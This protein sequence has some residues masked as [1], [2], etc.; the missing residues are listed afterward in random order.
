MTAVRS[1]EEALV[2]VTKANQ[3]LRQWAMAT[4]EDHPD[5]EVVSVALGK[6]LAASVTYYAQDRKQAMAILDAIAEL[7]EEYITQFFS[8]RASG[9]TVQWGGYAQE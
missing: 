1:E 8:L 5:C 7:G 2:L 6:L 3:L 4:G 9:Q